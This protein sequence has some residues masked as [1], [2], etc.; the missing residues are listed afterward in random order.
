VTPNQL[1]AK[2]AGSENAE[3][4]G[5][6]FVRP[7]LRRHYTRDAALKGSAWNLTDEQRDAVTAAYKARQ[8]GKPFD[9]VTWRKA[10][11]A[12]RTAGTPAVTTSV[13]ESS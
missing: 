12:R 7:F 4:V 8:A 3:R 2:L 10:R 6:A 5:K 13:A 11:R 9:F 1:A